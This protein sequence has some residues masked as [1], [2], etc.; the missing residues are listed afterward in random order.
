MEDDDD[1]L[2]SPISMLPWTLVLVDRMKTI[3]FLPDRTLLSPAVAQILSMGRDLSP[4]D[5]SGLIK[6]FGKTAM[7]KLGLDRGYRGDGRRTKAN[8]AFEISEFAM[9]AD[10]TVSTMKAKAQVGPLYVWTCRCKSQDVERLVKDVMLNRV[11]V[12]SDE[13]D[14]AIS[15]RSRDIAKHIETPRELM[16][17]KRALKHVGDRLDAGMLVGVGLRYGILS[18]SSMTKVYG[19]DPMSSIDDELDNVRQSPNSLLIDESSLSI[20]SYS[21]MDC[22]LFAC[23]PESLSTSKRS[24][25]FHDL[26]NSTSDFSGK[27]EDELKIQLYRNPTPLVA[28]ARVDACWVNDI[29]VL[30]DRKTMTTKDRDV[31]QEY[32]NIELTDTEPMARLIS[33][34]HNR[35][36]VLN[37]FGVIPLAR[38]IIHDFIKFRAPMG[39]GDHLILWSLMDQTVPMA[40]IL[41]KNVELTA[42]SGT[43]NVSHT[44]SIRDME[45]TV[46]R[47]SATSYMQ[48][49]GNAPIKTIHDL[50]QVVM[51]ARPFV[52]FQPN[53]KSNEKKHEEVDTIRFV[54]SNI[55]VNVQSKIKFRFQVKL[56]LVSPMSV[57]AWDRGVRLCLRVVA[58]FFSGP[59]IEF[60]Y[61]SLEDD[62]KKEESDFLQDDD[63]FMQ[64][65]F[66]DMDDD[67]T[68]D[69]VSQEEDVSQQD[70]HHQQENHES[71]HKNAN[72]NDAE[73]MIL[74]NL[75][76]AD[77][78]LFEYPVVDSRTIKY[79]TLCQKHRQPIVVSRDE[80]DGFD[81]AKKKYGHGA[82]AY[83]STSELA[84]KNRYICPTV[85]CPTS[86]IPMSI[87]EFN[88]NGRSC[89]APG[90]KAIVRSQEQELFAGYQ[91]P[92]KHAERLCIPCCF[93][94]P[95]DVSRWKCDARYADHDIEMNKSKYSQYIMSRTSRLLEQRLGLLPEYLERVF[96]N[97]PTERGTRHDGSGNFTKNTQCF[98]RVGIDVDAQQ[99]F[100]SCM[101]VALDNPKIKSVDNVVD[102]I[103]KKITPELFVELYD[104]MVMR[105]FVDMVKTNI[106]SS[107][108]EEAKTRE[109]IRDHPEY[110][111]AYGLLDFDKLTDMEIRREALIAS[112][113]RRFKVYINDKNVE[114]KPD[115]LGDL[116]V[117]ASWLNVALTRFV[118]IDGDEMTMTTIDIDVH[119]PIKFVLSTYGGRVYEM[120]GHVSHKK[121]LSLTKKSKTATLE[122]DI[123]DLPHHLHDIIDRP[124]LNKAQLDASRI[125][126]KIHKGREFVDKI[127]LSYDRAMIGFTCKSNSRFVQLVTPAQPFPLTLGQSY[128][129]ENE[130]TMQG[131]VDLALFMMGC[132]VQQA[133]PRANSIETEDPSKLM[134]IDALRNPLSP[135]PFEAKA[136]VLA[137]AMHCDTESAKKI[138]MGQPQSVIPRVLSDCHEFDFDE[139]HNEDAI[140]DA[141]TDP[142]RRIDENK[143]TIMMPVPKVMSSRES[144][145]AARKKKAGLSGE[146][147]PIKYKWRSFLPGFEVLY[148]QDTIW[149]IFERVNTILNR[150]RK[151]GGEGL[152]AITTA[153]IANDEEMLI[154]VSDTS[155]AMEGLEPHVIRKRILSGSSYPPSFAEICVLSRLVDVRVVILK[156]KNNGD[157]DDDGF[158]CMN[159]DPKTDP[160]P[161]VI[162]FQHKV[163]TLRNVDVFLPIVHDRQ[164]IVNGTGTFSKEFASL[165]TERCSCK[166]CW[167][168]RCVLVIDEI[169]RKKKSHMDS[170]LAATIKKMYHKKN[171]RWNRSPRDA[172][173][174]TST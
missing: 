110:A 33:S 74:A 5:V 155:A 78:R 13:I 168:E 174:S 47:A 23:G 121:A 158:F 55:S 2:G 54:L 167:D 25:Y 59:N 152:K 83:G 117:V 36:K 40:T 113:F 30:N 125:Y 42:I 58:Y 153:F 100:L 56:S 14:D 137:R 8:W 159:S 170:L 70:R 82:L 164:D 150:K 28:H 81:K 84:D 88:A 107:D 87:E 15:K 120:I 92:S 127:V 149:D 138:L 115:M 39:I 160:S 21:P 29:V 66:R 105:T 50:E 35:A 91:D 38:R 123:E 12:A 45:G 11:V 104:G 130:F 109:F 68:Q 62:S 80:L 116:F 173:E 142:F 124:P 162:V 131:R 141:F 148:S 161:M 20:A 63:E 89:P 151:L 93:S 145:V 118:Y 144:I 99:P 157:A 4:L 171:R 126:D 65:Y 6:A 61:Q 17:F 111:K 60:S 135:L 32:T 143:D 154:Q 106:D 147:R 166:A 10:D 69:D 77:A 37:S 41:G 16:S 53:R 7:R 140:L 19:V 119:R 49:D 86:R 31:L 57:E 97:V 103:S 163:D 114:K 101:V 129:F 67:K 139:F 18:K 1:L 27:K 98:V 146:F 133:N 95:K 9:F 108:V 44:R 75:K 90:E 26:P 72:N 136:I 22:E 64:D 76:T 172:L 165:M 156:R 3:I 102:I 51:A 96:G 112:A 34:R 128:V 52:T 71:A 94:K 24:F 46:M 85:W 79:S 134:L 122:Y 169:A 43:R 73:K 132:E 48:I